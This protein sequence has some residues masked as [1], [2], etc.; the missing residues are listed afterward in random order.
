M[1][2]C[3]YTCVFWTFS[4]VVFQVQV[5][6][7]VHTVVS[8]FHRIL[9]MCRIRDILAHRRTW[10]WE[11]DHVY[12]AA[13]SLSVCICV[14]Y[15]NLFLLVFGR[16]VADENVCDFFNSFSF[17]TQIWN[18]FIKRKRK[19]NQIRLKKNLHFFV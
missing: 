8:F 10:I 5:R 12:I 7:V 11:I 9:E 3:T 19:L 16:V 13:F 18:L 2:V 15:I 17:I 14:V 4:S 1:Y 6:F